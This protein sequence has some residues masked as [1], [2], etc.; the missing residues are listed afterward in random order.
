[1]SAIKAKNT[2]PEIAVRKA[3]W[4]EGLKGYRLHEKKAGRADI[5]Y[6]RSRLAIFIHGC[7][8]HRC[9]KCDLPVPKNNQN[10]WKEKFKRNVERD[11]KKRLFL[12]QQ[13]WKVLS[14]WECEVKDLL[15][16]IMQ[17][18]RNNL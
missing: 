10:F 9:P 7:Y 16:K 18:I 8:W 17:E 13:G 4:A 12:E 5:C 3:L 15:P 6:A 14:F 2:R 11:E 1:M